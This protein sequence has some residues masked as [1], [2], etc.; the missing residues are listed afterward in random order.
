LAQHPDFREPV[1]KFASF[2]GGPQIPKGLLAAAE[3]LFTLTAGAEIASGFMDRIFYGAGLTEGDQAL[4]FRFSAIS[5]AEW[6]QH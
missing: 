3:Y 1:K 4:V 2:K 6:R 5:L